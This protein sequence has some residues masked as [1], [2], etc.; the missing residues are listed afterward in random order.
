MGT[1]TLRVCDATIG[2]G[3]CNKPFSRV[4]II[5]E[6]DRCESCIRSNSPLTVTL[7]F[8]S[9]HVTSA[10]FGPICKSCFSREKLTVNAGRDEL[11]VRQLNFDLFS[12]RRDE[13]V[14]A[15][16]A[17]IAAYALRSDEKKK[18]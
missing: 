9:D 17:A 12:S 10:E 11:G 14:K 16:Q 2:D 6:Q 4:C 8:G 3:T 1:R 15:V 13:I 5:C 7:S 18:T